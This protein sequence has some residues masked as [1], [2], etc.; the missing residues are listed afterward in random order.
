MKQFLSRML[1]AIL[2]ALMATSFTAC[3]QTDT[4]HNTNTAETNTAT[5]TTVPQMTE[6]DYKACSLLGVESAYPDKPVILT[7][8]TPANEIMGEVTYDEFRYYEALYTS[9]FDNGDTSY[10]DSNPDMI[11]RVDSLI[12][13][14]LQRN[15]AVRAECESYGILLTEAEVTALDREIAE[16]V[17]AFGGR[18]TF[19]SALTAYGMTPYFY[20]LQS[21]TEELYRKLSAYYEESGI[22]LTSDEDIR[23]MLDTDDYIRAKH[24]LIKNDAGDDFEAN[25]ALANDILTKLQNGEDFDALMKAH[26]E[27]VDATGELN[28]P[29]GYYFF[30]GE[31]EESFENAAFAL[32]EGEL[33]GIVTSAYGYHIIYRLEKDAS[34]LDANLSS[35]KTAYEQLRFYQLLDDVVADWETVL[36]EGYETYI[37]PIF[38]KIDAPS[39]S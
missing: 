23:A 24:I 39:A 32:K 5:D 7:Y 14:E 28:G 13:A 2:A 16:L 30:R 6:E 38:A 3:N 35:I 25:L 1:T 36:C 37:D 15:Y 34:Y 26:S 11:A 17:F 19:D 8:Q 9:Y 21:E 33:S 29:D 10:W 18:E 27:D 20:L 31:M 22:I 12:K 4:D